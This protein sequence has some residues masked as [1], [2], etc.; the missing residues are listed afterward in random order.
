[1]NVTLKFLS[2]KTGYSMITI[3]R[4]INHPHLVQRNSREKI[5]S[6][7]EKYQYSPNNVAKALV[8]NKTNIIHV[9]IP[10]DLSPTNQF[11]MQVN[12]GIGSYLGE[13]GYSVLIS[14]KWYRNQ[15]VDGLILMGLSMKDESHLR[16]LASEK[17]LVLFGHD[18]YVDSVDVDNIMGT[19][20]A[21]DHAIACGYKNI[22]FIGINQNKK[23]TKDRYM[24]YQKSLIKHH[25]EE[26]MDYVIFVDNNSDSGRQ[27]GIS[28]LTNHN[29]IDCIICSSD[30]I[31]TGVIQ[32]A[33]EL[34][35]P[36]PQKLGV[37]GYDGLGTE[38][39][40]H[41]KLTTIHQPIYEVGIE[42]AK[43][44]LHK[45]ENNDKKPIIKYHKPLL[46][47]GQS[48]KQK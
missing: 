29:E 20:I 43:L 45:I 41:P 35:C 32:A 4:V 27:A 17:P 3:S 16:K 1:M 21:T 33:K 38:L 14:S 28:L 30:D 10:E 26:N 37:I 15:S 36:I 6:A 5:L 2:E 31:A 9:Y 42:L 40:T 13:K 46:V 8:Y 23:F 47:V 48:T 18:E 34:N 19:E 39:I 24:G 25:I 12:A 11:V 44:V 22:A 7:I